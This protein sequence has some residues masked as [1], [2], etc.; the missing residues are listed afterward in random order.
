M[1]RKSVEV[2]PGDGCMAVAV[3]AARS[4]K[5][6]SSVYGY[7]HLRLSGNTMRSDRGMI[8]LDGE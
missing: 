4:L 2:G 1:I 3:A 5:T 7:T 6:R 8:G